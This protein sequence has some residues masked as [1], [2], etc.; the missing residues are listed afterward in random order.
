MP[1]NS[2]SLPILHVLRLSSSLLLGEKDYYSAE[3]RLLVKIG[4]TRTFS[5]HVEKYLRHGRGYPYVQQCKY[6][7]SMPR[8]EI[9]I[10]G[11]GPV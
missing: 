9:R 1:L 5:L 2:L 8:H 10:A 6:T 11:I 7:N 4:E 3:Y